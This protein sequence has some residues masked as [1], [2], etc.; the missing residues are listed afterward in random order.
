MLPALLG[1]RR[2]DWVVF[3][4]LNWLGVNSETRRLFPDLA[5]APEV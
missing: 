2:A 4:C 1:E 3:T 5:E